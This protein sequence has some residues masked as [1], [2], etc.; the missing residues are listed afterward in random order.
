MSFY[1][2]STPFPRYGYGNSYGYGLT[3]PY[4]IFDQYPYGGYWLQ[5]RQIVYNL[6]E[7]RTPHFENKKL[8][9]RGGRYY[10]KERNGREVDIGAMDISNALV[11][12]PRD[13]GTFDCIY[14]EIEGEGMQGKR[15]CQ[16][17]MEAIRKHNLLPYLPGFHRNPDCPPDYINAALFE[18]L[19]T[20]SETKFLNLP[21]HSGWNLL[22]SRWCFIAAESMI[23]QLAECYA[24]DIPLRQMSQT[25]KTLSDA[26]AELAALLPDNE[27]CHELINVNTSSIMLGPYVEQRLKPDH[28]IVVVVD[29]EKN[30]KLATVLL[31]N[32]RFSD[33]LVCSLLENKTELEDELASGWDCTVIF[34]DSSYVENKKRLDAGV[35]VLLQEL[36]RGQGLNEVNRKMIV[37][38]T[39]NPASYSPELPAVFI[40][41]TGCSEVKELDRLQQAIGTF[42]VALI[43]TLEKSDRDNNLVTAALKHTQLPQKTIENGGEIGMHTI[44]QCTNTILTDLGLFD[45]TQVSQ[46]DALFRSGADLAFDQDLSVVNEFRSVFSAMIEAGE[47]QVANQYGTPNYTDPTSMVML[48]DHYVNFSTQVLNCIVTRLKSTQRRNLVLRALTN[49]GKLHANNAYKRLLEVETAPGAVETLNFYSVPRK[50]LTPSCQAKLNGIRYA[51]YMF[52]R[53]DFPAGFV[54]II[55]GENGLVA[56]RVVDDSTDEAESIYASGKTRSGKTCLEENQAVIRANCGDITIVFDQTGSSS[57]DEQRKRLPENIID[58]YLSRWEI[59]EQGLPVDLLSLENCRS[60]SDKKVRLASVLSVLARLTGDVQLKKLNGRMKDLAKAIEAGKVH[61]L[62]D[63]LRFFDEDDS[64]QAEIKERLAEAFDDLEGLPNSQKTW[65]EF[66]AE[67]GKIIVISTAADGIR[68]SSQYIDA[69]LA[70]LF[71]WKQHNREERLTVVLDEIEDLCLDKDGPIDT[72]LRKGGKNRLS[73]LLASQ[74][75]STEKDRLGKLIGNCGMQLIFHPKDACID[76]IAKQYKIDRQELAA[77]EQGECFA[78]GGFFSKTHGKNMQATLRGKT[79]SAAKY[80]HLEPETDETEA[81]PAE[82]QPESQDLPTGQQELPECDKPEPD[83]PAPEPLVLPTEQSPSPDTEDDTPEEFLSESPEPTPIETALPEPEIAEDEAQPAPQESE[84]DEPETDSQEL[85]EAELQQQFRELKRRFSP[86]HPSWLSDLAEFFEVFLDKHHFE[87]PSE[88][89]S[90]QGRL[91]GFLYVSSDSFDY[92]NRLEA[93][94]KELWPDP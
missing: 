33:T 35:D 93:L 41:L 39:N 3:P 72:I 8:S 63:T 23:P 55:Q 11:V 76:E 18:E 60:M 34:R 54:P 48:D 79:Y 22:D 32:R 65:G 81:E 30:A 64:E 14:C 71:A 86:D 9:K 50:M 13:D 88:R 83:E 31:Q 7:Q 24:P 56:G 85:I 51:D 4:S 25:D 52:R 87:N 73:L 42:L 67:Q 10:M 45:R 17:P 69:L 2:L 84:S 28:V 47:L 68:K 70:S 91:H 75:Y 53:D 90:I 37:I 78:V 29:C 16:F 74:E 19:F 58:E 26:T 57:P 46:I 6:Y 82:T 38:I 5:P 43:R 40:D 21:L 61:C 44:M 36:H 1:P 89:D 59:G 15:P 20:N 94:F 62:A 49:C 27:A 80:L 12:N 66:L 77:L 92:R